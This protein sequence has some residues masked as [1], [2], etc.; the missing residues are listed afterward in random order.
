MPVSDCK[1]YSTQARSLL[2]QLPACQRVSEVCL[3]HLAWCQHVAGKR[4]WDYR[5]VWIRDASFVLYAF[6]RC[7]TLSMI[8]AH[9]PADSGSKMRPRRS[10]DGLS[11][12]ARNSRWWRH[13]ALLT[14]AQEGGS[15]QIMY[16]LHGEAVVEETELSHLS[17]YKGAKPVRIG[18]SRCIN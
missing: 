6:L 16:G 12:A 3:L 5:F 8:H 2:L 17:G 10:S 1:S 14:T 4:N 18:D 9:L 11:N 15:L 13:G 7:T